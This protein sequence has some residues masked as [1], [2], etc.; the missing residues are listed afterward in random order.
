VAWTLAR[1]YASRRMPVVEER[2]SGPEIGS[3]HR[4]RLAEELAAFR[5]ER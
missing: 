3:E 5:G 1:R 4:R 2:Q